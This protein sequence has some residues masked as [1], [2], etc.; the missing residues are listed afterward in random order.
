[1]ALESSLRLSTGIAGFDEILHGGLSP[2]AH[3]WCVAAQGQARPPWG[4]TF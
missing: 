2:D 4:C 3:T 1:M